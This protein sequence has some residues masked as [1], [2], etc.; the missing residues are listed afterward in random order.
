MTPEEMKQVVPAA[1]LSVC[2]TLRASGFEAWIVGGAVRDLVL[3]KTPSDWDVASDALPEAVL[4]VFDKTIATGLA[5]GTVTAIVGKGRAREQ[6][7]ITSFRGEGTYSDSRRPDS[8]HFGV[9]LDEDLLR[10]DFVINAMAYSPIDGVIHDPLGGVSDL[11]S[12]TLRAVGVAADRF[13]EDGLR[14]MRAVRFVSTLGFSMESSTEAALSTALDALAAVAQE[15]VRVELLKLL[16]GQAPSEALDIA[17]RSGILDVILPELQ[18]VDFDSALMRVSRLSP[19]PV[20]RLAALVSEVSVSKVEA[21]LRRLTMSNEDRQRILAMLRHQE[22]L[23]GAHGTDGDLRKHLSVV[24]RKYALDHLYIAE[25]IAC[26]KSEAGLLVAISR[27]R[28]ILEQ[29]CPLEIR[30]LAI[31]GGQVI[32][33]VGIEGRAVGD[34]MAMLLEHVLEHPQDNDLESLTRLAKEFQNAKSER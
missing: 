22:G 4:A 28:S 20:L 21:I 3:G 2:K 33:S 10:R 15:R 12:K 16:G 11:Q 27:A 1:V 19:D 14:I 26:Y 13:A 29:E 25:S 8:V 31:K 18:E 9:P 32:Q 5:H 6:V 30:D 7:E 34:M 24:G 23:A 17:R